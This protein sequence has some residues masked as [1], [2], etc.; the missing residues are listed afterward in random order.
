MTVAPCTNPVP[1]RFV[2]E[3]V[4]PCSP[5]LG[6][7]DVMVN[8]LGSA[9]ADPREVYP[10]LMARY[11]GVKIHM[12]GKEVRPGRKLGHVTAYGADL[13]DVREH[14]RGAVALLRGDIE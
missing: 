4:A 2:T 7:M 10:E 8:L 14:A 11:P 9:L 12:Y 1:A 3:T 5:V 13:A 6:A